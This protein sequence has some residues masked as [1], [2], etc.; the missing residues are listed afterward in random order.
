MSTPEEKTVLCG[1][2]AEWLAEVDGDDFQCVAGGYHLTMIRVRKNADFDYLYFQ[3]R[4]QGAAIERGNEFK[5]AGIY[6]KRDMRVYD[7]QYEIRSLEAEPNGFETRSEAALLKTVKTDVCCAVEA[8]IGDDRANLHMTEI[9]DA[10][11]LDQLADYSKYSAMETA[12][13]HYLSN[14]HDAYVFTYQCQYKPR[15]WTEDSFLTYILYPAGYVA[16]EAAAYIDGNQ[17]D[18]LAAF[19]EGDMIAAEYAALLANPLNPIQR[20]KRIMAALNASSAKTVTVTLC[21]ND[22]DFTFKAEAD[23]FR[24]DC[25]STY[26]DW[27]IA[28]ADRG[29]YARRFG[30]GIGYGPEDILRIEYARSVLYQA[31]EVP[32]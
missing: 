11:R 7:G 32:V 17:E 28:A 25:I 24:R 21:K 26:S 10:R 15:S 2:F 1:R 4:Y 16:A 18:M 30:R 23:Q 8:A 12:R 14:A 13:K 6:C 19:I 31:K 3:R 20:V 29:E 9:T 22:I 27:R 5:Y